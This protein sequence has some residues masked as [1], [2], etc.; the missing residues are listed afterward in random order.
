MNISKRCEPGP[1]PC[2][3]VQRKGLPEIMYWIRPVVGIDQ[4]E[5]IPDGLLEARWNG[6]TLWALVEID[7]ESNP[8]GESLQ[9]QQAASIPTIRVNPSTMSHGDFID[10]LA[11][12][13]LGFL[14]RAAA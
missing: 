7:D 4:G 6:V 13:V 12:W 14:A 10:H 2:L 11:A 1:V 3:H 9:G 5:V 8:T